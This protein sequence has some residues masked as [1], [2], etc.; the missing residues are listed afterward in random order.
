MRPGER[1]IVLED[2]EGLEAVPGRGVQAR[3]NGSLVYLG[4]R[5]MMELNGVSFDGLG[6]RI[7]GLTLEGKTTLLVA[8]DGKVLGA[9]GVADT[10]KPEASEVVAQLKGLGL[11]VIMLTGDSQR[12]AEAVA[13]R[14]GV[15]RVIAEVL[16]QNKADVVKDLQMK[17]LV[18]AMVGDGINDA[19]ALA[20]ADIGIAMGTGTRRGNGVGRHNPHAGR[21]ERSA[22]RLLPQP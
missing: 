14:V 12:T 6:A 4:T 16:P 17:G 19:P 5:A 22:E 3:V 9:I 15:D 2:V 11:Q 21:P 8:S 10:L 20:Q 13:S 1:G 7:D 18:V